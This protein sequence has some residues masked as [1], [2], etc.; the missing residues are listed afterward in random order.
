MRGILPSNLLRTT[1]T[2]GNNRDTIRQAERQLSE[3][4]RERGSEEHRAGKAA[5]LMKKVEG[6]EEPS[7]LYGEWEQ[8]IVYT[9]QQ[10]IHFQGIDFPQ[11]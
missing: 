5:S 11:L 4:A 8:L 10:P 7:S 9:A 1:N 3:V 2:R 6:Q